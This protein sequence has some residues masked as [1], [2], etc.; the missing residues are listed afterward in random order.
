MIV[1]CLGSCVSRVSLLKGERNQH[2]IYKGEEIDIKLQ[3][4]LDKHNIA[5]AMM[6]PPFDRTEVAAITDENMYDKSRLRSMKQMLN[7]D[8]IKMLLESNAEYLIMDL[9]DFHNSF[10]IYEN[11][12]FGTQANEFCNTK[13]YDKV[14]KKLTLMTSFFERLTYTYY[15][16]V[17]LFFEK[18]M[19]KYDSDHIILNRFRS[20]T[21][22]LLKDG[23]IASLPDNLK[24]SYQSNDKYNKQC[25]LLED[26]IIKKYNPYVIDLSKYYMSDENLWGRSG[27]HGAHYEKQFYRETYNQIVKIIKGDGANKYYDKP[28]FFNV[29]R[30][31]DEEDSKREFNVEKGFLALDYFI[32]SDDPLSLNIL[33]K[34]YIKAPNH[35]K[36]KNIEFI[37]NSF[38]K[39]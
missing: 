26:Y 14:F 22:A 11:T 23:Y 13:L 5:L 2:G 3:Y 4:F 29:N 32:D 18:I 37:K 24:M 28:E 30:E 31:A 16:L 20:N 10:L 17:D 8:T 1:N 35:E 34:L 27:I 36:L 25:R 7:K 39:S 33:E 9:Y 38:A 19:T 21:Y 12:A 15:P 6:P